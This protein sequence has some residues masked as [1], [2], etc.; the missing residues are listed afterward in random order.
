MGWKFD[1]G[2][3]G[4]EAFDQSQNGGEEGGEHAVAQ[5]S[6]VD[7]LPARLPAG[8]AAGAGGEKARTGGYRFVPVPA[9]AMQ[10][11]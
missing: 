2:E 1:I 5:T 8:G 11:I 6:E 9:W 3:C 10:T 7:L 4:A